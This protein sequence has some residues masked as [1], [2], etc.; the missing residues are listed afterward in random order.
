MTYYYKKFEF[1]AYTEADLL[2]NGRNGSSFGHGDSFTVGSPT[3]TMSTYDNDYS[4][5]GDGSYYGNGHAQD[6][7]GQLASVDGERVGSQMYAE[8]YHVLKGS[9]GQTYYMIEVKVECH[10]SAGAGNG[11]FTFYGAQPPAGTTLTNV[12]TCDVQ[13][14]WVDYR[15]L[16]AG[17]TAPANTPPTFTNVPRTAFSAS[18][19]TPS[20]SSTWPL[21][22]PMAM[23]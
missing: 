23:R 9:D 6:G 2:A 19:R 22:M 20:W 15:C 16:G 21:R 1:T 10:D 13:G 18:M 7:S 8:Q 3:V 17:E 5:S 11:Y 14:C 12:G 4:L